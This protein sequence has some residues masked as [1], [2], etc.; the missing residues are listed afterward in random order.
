[1]DYSLTTYD[2]I[3]T[4]KCV[5]TVLAT[6]ATINFQFPPRITNESNNSE[7]EAKDVW[8]I[9]QLKI[10]K[11]SGGRKLNMEW[12]YVCTDS[13]WN[14]TKISE[15]LRLLKAYF[16]E[17]KKEFYPVVL[18]QYTE[19]IPIPTQF[20]LMSCQI[21]YSPEIAT[22]GG[23]SHPLITKVG[24]SLEVAT[25]VSG[26]KGAGSDKLKQKPLRACDPRWY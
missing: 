7:W 4:A 6:G 12:D 26:N 19:V 20:R 3:L 21:D 18:I 22:S 25:T 14:P 17:Y 5:F 9:E 13:T 16:F 2:R 15:T 24:V 11:G 10:H 8:S 23:A 1:M